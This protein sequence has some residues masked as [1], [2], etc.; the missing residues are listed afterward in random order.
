MATVIPPPPKRVKV[1]PSANTIDR[2]AAAPTIIAQFR[3]SL[4]GTLLGPPL[5]LPADTTREGLELLVN[6][7]R[8][9]VRPLPARIEKN[10]IALLISF[11]RSVGGS[12]A[13]C[14]SYES[15]CLHC[16]DCRR[17]ETGG[18]SSHSDSQF[19]P[20]RFTPQA[21][22]ARQHGGRLCDRVRARGGLQSQ[23]DHEML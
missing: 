13:F 16:A 2:A 14:V 22:S 21:F 4:D 3:N 23:G 8:G 12:A 10:W 6:N 9:S 18:C 17:H 11:V 5:S 7:L 15:T 1:A 20:C 19:H